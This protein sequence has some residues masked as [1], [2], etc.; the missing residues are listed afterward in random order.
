MIKNFGGYFSSL[1]SLFLSIQK[2]IK[3]LLELLTRI[4]N[5]RLVYII[6][7]Q[8]HMLRNTYAPHPLGAHICAPYLYEHLQMYETLDLKIDEYTTDALL[9]MEHVI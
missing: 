2:D 7:G 4:L 6:I 5:E 1:K 8:I 3:R 9:W